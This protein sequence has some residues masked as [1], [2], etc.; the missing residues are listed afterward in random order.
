VLV[1]P[2]PVVL[3]LVLPLPLLLVCVLIL[4]VLFALL[5]LLVLVVMLVLLLMLVLLD[6]TDVESAA[7]LPMRESS[8]TAGTARTASFMATSVARERGR[9]P[10][11]SGRGVS[12]P[13]ALVALAILARGPVMAFGL[14]LATVARTLVID[15]PANRTA[16]RRAGAALA[17][18]RARGATDR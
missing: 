9:G 1:P 8:R 16:A 5:L 11:L 10:F 2:V 4:L 12:T 13:A 3:M 14:A 6:V 17:G 15:A 7:A 18:A